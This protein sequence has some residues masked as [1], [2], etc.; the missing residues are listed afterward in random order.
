MTPITTTQLTAALDWRYATKKFDAEK[1][2]TLGTSEQLAEVKRLGGS[3]VKNLARHQSVERIAGVAARDGGFGVMITNELTIRVVA[4]EIT[5]RAV[6][7]G[8][9]R[10]GAGAF[11]GKFGWGERAESHGGAIAQEAAGRDE[12]L[13]RGAVDDGIGAAGVVAYHPTDHC[14]ISGGGLG[15]EKE[16][17]GLQGEIQFIA[18]DARL[19]ADAT[20]GGIDRDD[21]VEVP[22]HIDH[23]AFAHDLTGEGGARGAGDE[24]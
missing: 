23:Q 20:L 4:Q 1:K 2:C 8:L 11:G 3:R 6:N 7:F 21:L 16:A 5:H 10:G 9:E 18:H 22:T 24:S 15:G 13:A 17:V 19:H 14:P 12:V